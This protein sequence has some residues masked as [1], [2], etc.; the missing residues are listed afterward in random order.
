MSAQALA[1]AAALAVPRRRGVLLAAALSTAAI[2]AA[3]GLLATSGYLI[4]RAA[5]E[6]PVLTLTVAIVGVRSFALAR[7]LLRYAERVASHDLALR[8]LG[9]LRARCYARLAPLVP[10]G[11]PG[12]RA[13]DLLT[14]FVGDVD[15]LQDLYVRALTPPVVAL[16]TIAV[17]AAAAAIV[18]PVVGLAL[19][20]TLMLA[21]V[22]LPLATGLAV[23]GAARRQGPLRGALTT[24]LVEALDGA[25]ELAVL[26]QTDTRLARLDA[27]D[28]ALG[29]AARRD[30]LAA[31]L[32]TAL[33]T[34]LTGAA[35]VV[36]LVTAVPLVHAGELDGVLLGLLALLALSSAEGITPLGEA[37]RR[38]GACAAA[39]ERLEE[40]T[41]ARPP[42]ADPDRPLPL[43]GAGHLVADN[44]TVAVGGHVVLDD[45]ALRIVPGR[46]IAVVGAN[47]AG[48]T[49]LGRALVR[50]LDPV[51]GCVTLGGTDVRAV[52]QD[53]LRRAVLLADQDA[54]VFATTIRENLLLA[55]RDADEDRL[56]SA[57]EAVGLDAEVA[58][59]PDGL[60]T[61][62]GTDG[63]ALSGGQ[64][65]RLL[66]ARALVSRARFLILDEP[67]AHLSAPAARALLERL[68]AEARTSGRG[69]LVLGHGA[70]DL[71]AFDA[72][73]ALEGG[74]LRRVPRSPRSVSATRAPRSAPAA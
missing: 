35:V 68:V 26:G 10:A 20:L 43:P 64:R 16:S 48:K 37:A 31:G 40:I 11:L 60:D 39:A 21:A 56:W 24:E 52:A 71:E 14:R 27:L 33:G 28:G 8:V 17:S 46:A 36:V 67:A 54:R 49:T 58:A 19:G 34:M 2:L 6:P 22:V 73:H 25:A 59:M 4:V 62:C 69:I 70:A 3:I 47:G 42:V 15:V 66:V 7:A 50:F 72:V 23:R 9:D 65:R 13:G 61:D 57:L 38:I 63:D 45:L 1:R 12:R 30:A 5:Q 53:D 29:R 44:L 55:D 18:A 74:R 41:A 51:D 32:A